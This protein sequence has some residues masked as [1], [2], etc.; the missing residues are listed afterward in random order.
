MPATEGTWQVAPR[1]DQSARWT[2]LAVT[3][4]L[5]FA[6]AIGIFL[7][8]R[9][10]IGATTSPLPPTT[11]VATAAA[12]TAW[13]I[14]IGLVRRA[15]ANTET[16]SGAIFT[17]WLPAITIV[18]FA[19]ACSYPSVRLIDWLVWSMAIVIA[20]CIR[21]LPLARKRVNKRS[22]PASSL[23][24]ARHQMLQ[25][26]T[27]FRTA[28][29]NELIHGSLIAEFAP[30]QRNATLYV[31][32]CPPFERLPAVEV[33]VVDDPFAT[34]NLAQLLHNGA[35]LDVRLPRPA[36]QN[37]RIAVEIAATEAPPS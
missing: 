30:G 25:Q 34:V 2:H 4:S 8:I 9:R 12:L 3:A 10:A 31:A 20:T 26:L 17:R 32:F 15:G 16:R 28:E 18:V 27:R 5:W 1:A 22:S 11:L 29:G 33:E 21:W 13:A 6:L 24:P 14:A 36:D 37:Q 7:A 19:V 23:A 35:Q